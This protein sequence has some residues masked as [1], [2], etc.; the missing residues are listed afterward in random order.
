MYY[1][2][3]IIHLG[4]IFFLLQFK[5]EPLTRVEENY[6][7]HYGKDK[8]ENV[9][10]KVYKAQP[11]SALNMR[12]N[13]NATP[14]SRTFGYGGHAGK[15]QYLMMGDIWIPMPRSGFFAEMR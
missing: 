3:K 6:L 7:Y 14:R 9:Q 11:S 1:T 12:D 13:I 5:V 2:G 8:R 4:A 10:K 15:S